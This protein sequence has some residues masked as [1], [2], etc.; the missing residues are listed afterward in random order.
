MR[1]C[2]FRQHHAPW[3]ERL[4]FLLISEQDEGLEIL[5]NVISRQKQVAVDI[6]TEVDSQNGKFIPLT[7]LLFYGNVFGEYILKKRF[8]GM[9]L[10]KTCLHY[11]F[12]ISALSL[13][14]WFQNFFF[15][16]YRLLALHTTSLVGLPL[17]FFHYLGSDAHY[18]C[19]FFP[20]WPPRISPS[21]IGWHCSLWEP[22][23]YADF[24]LY[25][26]HIWN[27]TQKEQ[28]RLYWCRIV[29]WAYMK[30]HRGRAN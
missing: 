29:L 17:H 20:S 23:I 21:P 13:Y 16:D 10:I 11:V 14:Q 4:N 3:K 19:L 27:T 30:H 26:D 9:W 8:L 25:S 5:S 7:S 18:H 24:G 12:T 6:G 22:Q 15:S 2:I 1:N 28:T